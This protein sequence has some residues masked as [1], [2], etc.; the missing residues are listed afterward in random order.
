MY[1]IGCGLDLEGVVCKPKTSLAPFNLPP[2]PL[3]WTPG[4]LDSWKATV[5]TLNCDCSVFLNAE[6]IH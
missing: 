5:A 2:D 1:D 3:D 4:D 6:K